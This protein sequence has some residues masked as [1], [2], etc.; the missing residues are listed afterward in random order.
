MKLLTKMLPLLVLF[1]F[2][3]LAAGSAADP[4]PVISIEENVT[5]ASPEGGDTTQH[6]TP[7]S[8]GASAEAE[9]EEDEVEGEGDPS[10]E[11][12]E[13][14]GTQNRWASYPNVCETFTVLEGEKLVKNEKGEKAYPVRHRRNRYDRKKSDQRRTRN[15]IR[16]VAREMGADEEG[17]YLVDMM[18]FHESSWM[19]ETIHILNGD[20]AANRDAWERH[21]YSEKREAELLET[22]GKTD[23]KSSKF[24]DIKS[25]LADLRLYKNNPYWNAQLEYVRQTP[26]RKIG[27]E[28]APAQEWKEYRSVW[29]FGYGLYG[30]NAVLFTHIIARD[31]PPWI[32]CA[33]EGIVA[34]V[35]AI[36]ALRE[37]QA[38]CQYLS[39]TVPEKYG[40]DGGSLRSI[41]R[42][43]G[44]GQCRQGMPGKAW[45]RVLASVSADAAKEGVTLSWETVPSLGVDFP[46]YEMVKKR[47]KLKYKKD[48]Q[49]RKIRT[50][51]EAVFAHMRAKAEKAGLLRPSPL[52]RKDPS[53]APVV[54]ALE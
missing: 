14:V 27:D 52:Q 50:N 13:N 16:L 35:N 48:A 7:A 5:A 10:E 24:W 46:Q 21:S 32:L 23:A 26:E 30:M 37:Q 4:D 38:T 11:A 20:L 3:S 8:V 28:T 49:G 9:T 22:L 31:A 44:S 54:V 12:E 25:T 51:P 53:T 34:T 36:W 19:V 42:R 1:V 18:A 33:D 41:I 2:V 6:E 43:W 40:S 29:A 15:L 17:Q 47:G 45:H 39:S